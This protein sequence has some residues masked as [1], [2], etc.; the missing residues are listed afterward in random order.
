[1]PTEVAGRYVVY[2]ATDVPGTALRCEYAGGAIALPNEVKAQIARHIDALRAKAAAE[3]REIRLEDRP[4][5]RLLGWHAEANYVTLRLGQTGYFHAIASATYRETWKP[6][7]QANALAVSVVTRT[8]DG[9][10][11]LEQRSS[12]VA[13]YPGAYH[14]IPA[15]QVEPPNSPV[16]TVYAELTE[17]LALARPE[18]A[19][20]RFLG[21]IQNVTNGKYETIFGLEIQSAWNDARRG[22]AVD[23]WA[24]DRVLAIPDTGERVGA[25]LLD[26][27][28]DMVPPGHAALL[29]YGRA[30]YGKTWYEDMLKRLVA[31][32]VA[33]PPGMLVE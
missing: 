13:E 25:W 23:A 21:I 32:E 33:M 6:A 17:E 3:D 30:R 24:T 7:L 8:A 27:L 20:G 28:D 22:N 29:L 9:S 12:R 1:M 31:R 11:L 16:D 18:V 26:H 5:A 2:L 4:I 15:G 14:V 10:V 19:E